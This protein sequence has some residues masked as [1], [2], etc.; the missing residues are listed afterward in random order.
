M[1]SFKIL[2]LTLFILI[3]AAGTKAQENGVLATANGQNY[4]VN[5]LDS[6]TRQMYETLN[7]RLADE[8]TALLNQQIAEMLFVDEAARRKTTVDELIEAEA[9]RR[10][11][12]PTEAQIKAVYDANAS[13]IGG[14]P[15]AEI[16]PQIV[17]FL[18]RE[19]RPK[20]LYDFVGELKTKNKTVMNAD[21]NSPGLLASDV[22]VTING[23]PVTMQSFNE[24]NGLAISDFQAETYD[25]TGGSL[26]Q[27]IYT[28]LL[29]LEAKNL[30]IGVE[31]LIAREISDKLR[32]FSD[33]ERDLLQTALQNK[34]FQKYNAKILLKE[35]APFVQKISTDDD[36]AKGTATAPVTVVMFSDFQCAACAATHPVLQKVL[37]GYGDKVRFVVRDFPLTQLHPN[38]FLAA[39]AADAAHAQGKFFEYTELLY[40]NQ[41]SLD[42]ASLKKFAAQIGLNQKQFDADFESEKFTEEIKKDIKDGQSYGINGTPTIFVN[43]VKV[44]V[45]LASSFRAAIERA[46]K[47]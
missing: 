10:I 15:L 4:T 35:P 2:G 31:D 8:K 5:D 41:N 18:Q 12:A 45:L 13:Q 26:K 3:F 7:K 6:E 11:T 1:K 46:L 36:P 39:K 14:R 24:K 21:V 43:G 42:A 33:E 44:R 25:R 28:S 20:A 38:A 40:A 9:K 16:R 17:E 27:L 22:L 37:A 19:S 32:D 29:N 47:K 30:G 23:K 34:L